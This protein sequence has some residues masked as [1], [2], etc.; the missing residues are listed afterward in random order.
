MA[1]GQAAHMRAVACGT[2]VAGALAVAVAAETASSAGMVS[3][4]PTSAKAARRI[5]E[6]LISFVPYPREALALRADAVGAEDGFGDRVACGV[7]GRESERDV[8][9]CWRG[10][11]HQVLAVA[12]P[13]PRHRG[14]ELAVVV[15]DLR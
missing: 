8:H 9:A 1:V 5:T 4:T 13:L 15:G 6:M 10:E 12:G 14:P 2:G 3:V 11:R 7:V